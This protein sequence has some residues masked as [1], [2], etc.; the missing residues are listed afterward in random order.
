MWER[1]F[2]IPDIHYV[3]YH[4]LA[5]LNSNKQAKPATYVIYITY[6]TI[7]QQGELNLCR[8]FIRC[9]EISLWVLFIH[10]GRFGLGQF[11][12]LVM[13]WLM[14][15]FSQDMNSIKTQDCNYLFT[16]ILLHPY[17]YNLWLKSC[18]LFGIFN[19]IILC[20]NNNVTFIRCAVCCFAHEIKVLSQHFLWF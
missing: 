15:V 7:R 3:I 17:C 12:K 18:S 9:K 11:M 14:Y 4:W 20:R 2:E 10:Y 8:G 1:G 16:I 13:L 19:H 6:T 5:T